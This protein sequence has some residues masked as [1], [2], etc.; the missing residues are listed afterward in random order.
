MAMQVGKGWPQGQPIT[1]W[2]EM[3][4]SLA[5]CRIELVKRE[6]ELAFM[7]V[8]HGTG[9]TLTRL[10]EE[11]RKEIARIDSLFEDPA[12]DSPPTVAT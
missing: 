5:E 11:A 6:S 3:V 1:Q 8:K 7:A 12:K 10:M 4:R 9:P 2:P